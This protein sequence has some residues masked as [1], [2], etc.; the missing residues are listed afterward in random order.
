MRDAP[1][2][3]RCA[4]GFHRLDRV[5]DGSL[6]FR[7][8]LRHVEE[9]GVWQTD[10]MPAS[11]P[12]SPDT[13]SLTGTSTEHS[14]CGSYPA[15]GLQITKRNRARCASSDRCCPGLAPSG[16]QPL[17]LTRPNVCLMPLMPQNDDL[18]AHG[19]D[20]PGIGTKTAEHQTGRRRPT[21]VPEL[22]PPVNAI[23][24]LGILRNVETRCSGSGNP[25]AYSFSTQLAEA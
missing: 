18:P 21:P 10:I 22:E 15:Y 19:L 7:I 17:L 8:E 20:P 5:H 3:D 2:D 16:T 4:R 11:E 6:D 12:S 25:I 14:S 23:C 1:R 24:I 13:M 9:I